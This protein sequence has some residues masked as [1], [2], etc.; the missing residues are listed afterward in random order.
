MHAPSAAWLVA[1]TRRAE[2][3]AEITA[4]STAKHDK[5]SRPVYDG[6]PRRGCAAVR[7]LSKGPPREERNP[8][9]QTESAPKRD[10]T[11]GRQAGKHTNT[12]PNIKGNNQFLVRLV[13]SGR[14]EHSRQT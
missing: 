12:T 2:R 9:A 1:R 13:R 8:P 7:A 14:K 3:I 6:S 10:T 5:A 11:C 4:A